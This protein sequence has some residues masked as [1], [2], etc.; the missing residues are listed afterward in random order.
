MDSKQFDELE[1][2]LKKAVHVAK[3]RAAPKTIYVMVTPAQIKAVRRKT[4]MS[5]ADFARTFHLSLDT[6][7]GWEQGKRSPDAAASNY[8]RL[9]QANPEFV[10][11]TMWAGP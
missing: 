11:E 2:N 1:S 6:V 10:Q 3:G 9:I 5:Q 8:L 7:K 4:G